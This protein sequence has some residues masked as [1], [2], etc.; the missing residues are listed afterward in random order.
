MMIE[1]DLGRHVERGR[2]QIGAEVRRLN[3]AVLDAEV[4]GERVADRLRDAAF[5][6][7]LDLLAVDRAAD[8][9]AR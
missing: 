5:D 1:I 8:V 7:R 9:V 2:Q 6:L 3:A 4:F